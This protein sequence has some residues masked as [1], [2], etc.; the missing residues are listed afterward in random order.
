MFIVLYETETDVKRKGSTC[1]SFE[2]EK[3]FPQFNHNHRF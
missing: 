2:L 1:E 3:A